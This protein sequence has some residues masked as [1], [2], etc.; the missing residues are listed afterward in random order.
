RSILASFLAAPALPFAGSAP[1]RAQAPLLPR[2]PACDDGDEPTVA[3][4]EG[5]FF[6]PDAPLRH[7]LAGD[8]PGGE[9]IT[10]AGFVLDTACRPMPGALVQIWHAD[11]RGAYDN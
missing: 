9:R 6:K 10:V 1:V 8:A 3:Q 2:T 5:P 4:T 7:D 11:E